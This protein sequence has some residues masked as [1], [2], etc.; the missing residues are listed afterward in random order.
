MSFQGAVELSVPGSVCRSSPDPTTALVPAAANATRV[1]DAAD[2][3]G[4][5]A[6]DR[7]ADLAV[8]RMPTW[9]QAP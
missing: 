4:T 5:I 6:P 1:L 3:T 8:F 9:D 7:P 2:R